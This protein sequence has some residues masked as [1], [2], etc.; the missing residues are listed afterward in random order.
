MA[1]DVPVDQFPELARLCS[2]LGEVRG[3]KAVASEL[4]H[5]TIQFLG[6][7]GPGQVDSIDDRMA[8]AASESAV[9]HLEL[10]GLGAFPSP[11][12]AQ[13][14]WVGCGS[15]ELTEF[16]GRMR[17]ALAGSGMSA[18][19]PFQ[20]HITIG[21]VKRA[22]DQNALVRLLDSAHDHSFGRFEVTELS[23]KRSDLGPTGPRY[24]ALKVW[25]LGARPAH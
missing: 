22:P 18:D 9:F 2:E 5:L 17:Q 11:S 23:L 3:V 13:V 6:D 19:K 8:A 1:I 15:V 10:S 14:I 20:A 21:R 16:A 4:L 7:V 25:P 24:S 12:R